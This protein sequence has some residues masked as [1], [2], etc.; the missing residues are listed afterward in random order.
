MPKHVL[1]GSLPSVL[2]GMLWTSGMQQSN[3]GGS[4]LLLLVTC[5][6]PEAK[7]ECPIWFFLVS[8]FYRDALYLESLSLWLSLIGEAYDKSGHEVFDKSDFWSLQS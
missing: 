2:Q 6:P 4:S 8:D 1:T 3:P 5:L 7:G